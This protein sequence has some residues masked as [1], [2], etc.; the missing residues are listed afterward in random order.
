MVKILSAALIRNWN[1]NSDMLPQ[2][3]LILAIIFW[4]A[5]SSL[6]ALADVVILKNGK[7]IKVEKVWQENGQTWVVIDGMRARIPHNKVRR[8]ESHSNSGTRNVDLK[9]EKSPARV[10]I[11]EF[12]NQ[13]PTACHYLHR[14]PFPQ[15]ARPL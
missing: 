6:S 15:I 2:R 12:G 1:S 10:Q 11:A 9:Q 8:I 13:P 5:L 14:H 7:E 4:M 3:Y